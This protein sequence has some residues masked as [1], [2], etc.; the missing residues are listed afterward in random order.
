MLGGLSGGS[1]DS[2]AAAVMVGVD[3][4]RQWIMESVCLLVTLGRI[5]R[6]LAEYCPVSAWRVMHLCTYDW[7]WYTQP[8]CYGSF[9]QSLFTQDNNLS[10]FARRNICFLTH[11]LLSNDNAHKCVSDRCLDSSRWV[12]HNILIGRWLNY[13]ASIAWSLS[14]RCMLRNRLTNNKYIHI[15]VWF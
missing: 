8:G 10:H 13:H 5:D 3:F 9:C 4:A 7:L 15:G 1:R 2:I 14:L 6:F 12:L 11:F